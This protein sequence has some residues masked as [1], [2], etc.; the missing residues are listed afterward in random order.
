MN[1]NVKKNKDFRYSICKSPIT[2]KFGVVDTDG[3]AIIPF[4]YDIIFDIIDEKYFI[5]GNKA[6][7]L[8]SYNYITTYKYGIVDI[9][10]NVIIDIKY[11]SLYKNGDVIYCQENW[12]E[13][14]NKQTILGQ[15]IWENKS[16]TLYLNNVIL[17]QSDTIAIYKDKGGYKKID[18]RGQIIDEADCNDIEWFNR[19]QKRLN[20]N[21]E[22]E[23]VVL[24]LDLALVNPAKWKKYEE[25]FSFEVNPNNLYDITLSINEQQSFYLNG[26]EIELDTFLCIYRVDGRHKIYT[27]IFDENLKLLY[28]DETGFSIMSKFH[29]RLIINNNLIIDRYGNLYNFDSSE[30][31]I[32]SV[33]YNDYALIYK[34]QK[35]GYMN[36][37]GKIVVPIIFPFPIFEKF[38]ED[39][40]SPFDYTSAEDAYEGDSDALWNTE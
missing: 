6:Y 30:G 19:E 16:G 14:L 9:N 2:Q 15:Y 27:G 8:S 10:N 28:Y 3:Q 13:P 39:Y 4:I 1:F 36:N 37:C 12:D 11:Y 34:D 5:V 18:C 31:V 26:F 22:D 17:V 35:M 32:W 29:N 38:E 40:K 33:D 23:S 20:G 24:L 25:K 21:I 7:P